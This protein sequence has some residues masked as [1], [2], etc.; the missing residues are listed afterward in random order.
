MDAFHIQSNVVNKQ[1][2]SLYIVF[3]G[4]KCRNTQGF[5]FVYSILKRFREKPLACSVKSINKPYRRFSPPTKNYR[6]CNQPGPTRQICITRLNYNAH[7]TC[8]PR[9]ARYNGSEVYG[10]EWLSE[11]D[12]YFF[13]CVLYESESMYSTY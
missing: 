10:G 8:G 2:L 9:P 4:L 7:A 3:N 1:I 6:N 12:N 5:T 13:Q 11:V